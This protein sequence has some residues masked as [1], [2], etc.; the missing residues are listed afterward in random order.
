VCEDVPVIFPGSGDYALTFPVKQ[1][2][3]CLLIFCERS[4]DNWNEKGDVQEQSDYRQHHAADAIAIVGLRSQPN[5]FDNFDNSHAQLRSKDGSTLITLDKGG[6]V[7]VKADTIKLDGDVE[8][9][10]NVR[11]DKGAVFHD[12]VTAQN[13]SVHTHVH[14][15]VQ[16]GGATSGPPQ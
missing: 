11:A 8:I 13:T 10:G 7:T 6:I 12:D 2:D 14:S 15:G 3:E 4:I 1:G 16:S 9:S 5:V